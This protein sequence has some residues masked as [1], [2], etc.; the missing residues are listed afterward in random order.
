[1]RKGGTSRFKRLTEHQTIRT[2]RETPSAYHNQTLNI[3]NKERI[4]K[5]QK[6][7]DRSHTKENPLD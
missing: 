4:L 6:R 5:P 2:G 7:K 3:Q 1:L